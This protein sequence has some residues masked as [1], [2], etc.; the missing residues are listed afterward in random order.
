VC[1]STLTNPNNGCV[2]ANVFGQGSISAAAVAYYSG[3][4][5][6]SQEQ[7]QD[8]YAFKIDGQP[9]EMWAG[10]VAMAF[11]GE[12]RKEE[13]T[14]TS[15]PISQAN[16]WRQINT[17]PLSGDLNVKEGFLE[18]GVPLLK[19]V[20]AVHLL[21]LNAAVRST[22]YSTS[23]SVTTWKGGFNYEPIEDLRFRG[24]V[25]RDIRAPNINELYSGRALQIP[26]I[27]DPFKPGT[28]RNANVTIGGN[29]NLF[30]EHAL[31]YTF[32]ATWQPGWVQGLKASID[33]YSIDLKDAIQ[34]LNGQQVVDG[35]FKGQTVL[36][37]QITRGSD[38]FISSV[39]A[40]LL[41]T[42]ETKTDGVDFELGYAYDIGE[43]KLAFRMLTTYVS[44]LVNTI[45]NV[46]TN[47]AGQVG[48]G[49]GIPHWR[50]NLGMDYR[51]SKYN[52]GVLLRYV[53]GGKYD[54]TLIEPYGNINFNSINDNTISGRYYVDLNG[55]YK[56][57]ENFD[58]FAKVNNLLDK[59]PP[60]TPSV[61]TQSQYAASPF[62]DRVGRFYTAGVRVR[63]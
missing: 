42:A 16:G 13:I 23:G 28:Q 33:Y 1:R 39:S 12:Y 15:D 22:D 45:G 10:P 47:R 25:S 17:Q 5:S 40:I 21:D 3:T 27:I 46:P 32:G 30:P 52:A 36:C 59:E 58:L 51:A 50:G 44:R 31:S 24:T 34:S 11:G 41:N 7:K 4:S 60:A 8:V 61:I 37:S 63:F 14:V 55:S 29:P 26:S 53:Q 49:A 43:G 48:S 35:C 62:Y 9:F 2:P 56:L 54:N 18:V 57:T 19:N 6:L 38:G 20:T